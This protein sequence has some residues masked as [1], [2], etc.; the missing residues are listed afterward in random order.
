MKRNRALLISVIKRL[1]NRKL[2]QGFVGWRDY[3]RKQD[4]AKLGQAADELR[5][6]KLKYMQQAVLRALQSK[7][8]AAWNTWWG[9]VLLHR[10][11]KVVYKKWSMTA[12]SKSFESWVSF[13]DDVKRNRVL[14]RRALMKMKKRTLALSFYEWET[15]AEHE[16]KKREGFLE[17][18]SAEKE[19]LVEVRRAYVRKAVGAWRKRRLNAAFIGWRTIHCEIISNRVKVRRVLLRIKNRLA[20]ASFHGWLQVAKDRKLN[21][22]R[23]QKTLKRMIHRQM[24]GAFDGW[25]SHVEQRKRARAVVT[26]ILYKMKHKELHM[27]WSHWSRL[28]LLGELKDDKPRGCIECGKPYENVRP[29]EKPDM[30]CSHCH[31]YTIK[32]MKDS[33]IVKLLKLIKVMRSEHQ[34]KGAMHVAHPKDWTNY[35]ADAR[36]PQY[37]ATEDDHCLWAHSKS[38]ADRLKQNRYFAAI[39]KKPNVLRRSKLLIR[40]TAQEQLKRI[41][42]KVN[43]VRRKEGDSAAFLA[44]LFER[45]EK[46]NGG[47]DALLSWHDVV[48]AINGLADQY[49]ASNIHYEEKFLAFLEAKSAGDDVA[50]AEEENQ[51]VPK[52]V[53]LRAFV[54]FACLEQIIFQKEARSPVRPLSAVPRPR[55]LSP[56]DSF[57]RPKSAQASLFANHSPPTGGAA[58]A[59]RALRQSDS[60]EEISLVSPLPPLEDATL[61][62]LEN[63]RE[64]LKKAEEERK[65]QEAMLQEKELLCRGLI[66]AREEAE[67]KITKLEVAMNRNN[68]KSSRGILRRDR[69]R[70]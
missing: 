26:N 53:K 14:V 46:T 25:C 56:Y 61:A 39:E 58:S 44:E 49:D 21:R 47:E 5:R 37:K 8:T 18:T 12:V 65:K 6:K 9:E 7:I 50:G 55:G 63:L 59:I 68:K 10:K 1:L 45:F 17:A 54:E 40:R 41:N 31:D 16:K 35:T 69:R 32:D 34:F 11:M 23:V 57:P 42:A 29:S 60:V 38:V 36:I 51:V 4:L 15:Y 13:V 22:H 66:R 2:A 70:K 67:K 19:K 28:T 30:V 52:S 64:S 3:L 24:S 48:R 27:A 20:S 33:D 43:L 62:E